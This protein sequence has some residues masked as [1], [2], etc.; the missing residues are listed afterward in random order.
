MYDSGFYFGGRIECSGWYQKQCFDFVV[1]LQY[2]IE[3]IIGFVVDFGYYVINYFFLQY[4]MYVGNVRMILYQM[5]QQG[6][7]NIIGQ[8]VDDV[9]FVC[10]QV[11]IDLLII[12]FESIFFVNM[13]VI[14]GGKVNF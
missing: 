13:E 9:D 4:K 5:E 6:G 10:L 12:E 11:V 7:G 8:V 2:N 3:M 14:V 1:I